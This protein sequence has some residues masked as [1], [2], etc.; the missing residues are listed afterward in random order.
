MK[1]VIIMQAR[2]T[3]TR[4]PGKVLKDISGRPMLS[5][6]IERL[7][8][9]QNIDRITIATT[10]NATDDP[11]VSLAER[12]HIS[13]F[14]GSEHDVLSRYVGASVKFE[15]D[16]IV[17]ITA[18]CPLIDPETLDNVVEQLIAR[19][20]EY[21]YASNVIERT[22]P[23]GLDTEAFFLK[24]LMRCDQLGKSERSREHVTSLIRE[25]RPDAFRCL[26][27]KD[28][29]D[30]SDLRWTVDTKAD[31]EFMRSIYTAMNVTEKQPTYYEMVEFVRSRPELTTIN[32]E[33][34]TWDPV[35]VKSS[36]H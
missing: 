3:S 28:T 2:M 13:V 31:L 11:I 5:H 12:E 4:L 25:E 20:D 19:K 16:L 18:D 14:R 10:T 21:D 35:D 26:S 15:A 36:P 7:R 30:N 1:R 29:Q 27:I 8:R 9:C 34:K 32:S 24:T 6:Q 17:R 22:Y 23:R 33:E